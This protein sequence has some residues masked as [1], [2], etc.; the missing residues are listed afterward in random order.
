MNRFC[1]YFIGLPV[2]FLLGLSFNSCEKDTPDCFEPSSVLTRARFVIK[3]SVHVDTLIDSVYVDTTIVQY[4]D[5]LF[6][7][8]VMVSLNMPQNLIVYGTPVNNYMGFPFNPDSGRILYALQYDTTRALRDTLTYFYHSSVH[9]I[10]NACGFT[11]F[12]HIDSME[13]TRHLIDSFTI[14]ERDVTDK[15]SDRHVTLYFFN[16]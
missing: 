11:H 4:R 15:A 12:Y 9:F 10:S 14:N 6:K 1:K 2:L 5:T 8:P 7:S 16:Q 3:D 13:A